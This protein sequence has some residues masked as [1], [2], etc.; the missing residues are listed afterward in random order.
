M[1]EARVRVIVRSLMAAGLSNRWALIARDMLKRGCYVFGTP[2]A[3]SEWYV[4]EVSWGWTIGCK[5]AS[6][7]NGENGE[8]VRELI[9]NWPHG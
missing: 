3:T 1:N 5:S 4:G 6:F 7:S 2:E 8:S 9:V